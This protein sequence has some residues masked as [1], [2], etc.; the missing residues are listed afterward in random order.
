MWH[1]ATSNS[2][3]CCCDPASTIHHKPT[4]SPT[5]Q[6]IMLQILSHTYSVNHNYATKIIPRQ[7][8]WHCHHDKINVRVHL[9]NEEECQVTAI[10]YTHQWHLPLLSLKDDIHSRVGKRG[11]ASA[12]KEKAGMVHS[13]TGRMQGV[14]VKLW[15]PLRTCAISQ[16]LRGVLTTRRYTKPRYLTFTF[17][18]PQRAE[19]YRVDLE[20][21]AISSSAYHF[22]RRPAASP[23]TQQGRCCP[24]S[25]HGWS[26]RAILSRPQ[27]PADWTQPNTWT[28]DGTCQT[29]KQY[30]MKYA[31]VKCNDLTRQMK[32]E[33]TYKLAV[34]V[35]S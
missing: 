30:D 17:T 13:V 6:K 10:I 21:T 3:C 19:L 24:W 33:E 4:I 25:W 23:A 9:T 15:D 20:M 27:L 14:Q 7:R 12:G 29:T 31:D 32:H 5:C 2:C 22:P 28:P 35:I 8:L 18:I 16:R 26:C 11:P 34:H 1:V